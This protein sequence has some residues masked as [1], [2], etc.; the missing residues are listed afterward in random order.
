MEHLL[1]AMGETEIIAEGAQG[2][3]APNFDHAMRIRGHLQAMLDVE[4]QKQRSR[5]TSL[6]VNIGVPMTP[7][8]TRRR[9]GSWFL[10]RSMN[11][12]TGTRTEA[13]QRRSSTKRCIPVST[14]TSNRRCGTW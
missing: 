12:R 8:N 10:K 11:L 6:I 7:S 4:L 13:S 1:E 5:D 14:R 2:A 3:G 9:S